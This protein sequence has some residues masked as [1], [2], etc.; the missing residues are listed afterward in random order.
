MKR[1]CA[2]CNKDMGVKEPLDNKGE[3]HGICPP[4]KEKF[5]KGVRK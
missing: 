2:W 3:T 5:T 1:V 4:C